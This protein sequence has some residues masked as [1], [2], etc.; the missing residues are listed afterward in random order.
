MKSFLIAIII[1]STVALLSYVLHKISEKMVTKT[2]PFTPYFENRK[3]HNWKSVAEW[4]YFIAEVIGMLS[5]C[6]W[7]W[8]LYCVIVP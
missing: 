7:F 1:F 5:V 8:F 6:G 3:S 2:N 4:S